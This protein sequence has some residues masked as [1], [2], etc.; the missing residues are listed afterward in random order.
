MTLIAE[1]KMNQ[2]FDRPNVVVTGGAGFIGSWL[3][4]ELLKTSKVI[5]VDN[6]STGQRSNIEFLLPDPNF[7]FI[8][9]D[10]TEPLDLEAYPE[11]EM[12]QIKVQ[13][14]QEVYGL[15]CP[16]IAK[17]YTTMPLATALANSYGV[18]NA[19]EL[20]RRSNAKFLQAST[21]SVYGAPPLDDE[22]LHEDDWGRI[23]PVGH[24]AAYNE[25]KRF[26]ETLVSVYRSAYNLD[27]KIARVFNTYGPHMRTGQGLMIPDFIEQAL[28]NQPL[29]V[30]GGEE[31]ITTYCY[32]QDMVEGLMRVMA[33]PESG[34]INLGNP[35]DCKIADVARK[36]ITLTNSTSQIQI[37]DPLPHTHRQGL[38]DITI[39]KEKLSWFPLTNL[40]EGLIQ[41]IDYVRSH[42]G[43]LNVS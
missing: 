5:C 3:C 18:R 38:P 25:G 14:V 1:N 35:Q 4:Q 40:D 23:N 22:F 24:R 17:D 30:H 7:K 11:L 10:I 34:P 28:D 20:A 15:A 6:F 12:F 21:A 29:I 36:I 2:V 16:T 43:L 9:H 42:R 31:M 13:G 41:T 39:A 19:L 37:A 8:N 32:V 26:A 27:A 33:G